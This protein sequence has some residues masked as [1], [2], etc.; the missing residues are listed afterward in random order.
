VPS[1]H[2]VDELT[3]NR[4]LLDITHYIRREPQHRFPI[5]GGS[6]GNVFRGTYSWRDANDDTPH[7][8]NVV[9]K[10]LMGTS[11]EKQKVEQ[12][13]N[14]EIATWR[15]LKHP[16]VAELLGIAYLNPTLPPGLVSRFAHRHDFLAY[17]GRHPDRKRRMV[18][19]NYLTLWQIGLL[20]YIFEGSGDSLW[21]GIFACKRHCAR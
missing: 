13:L 20:N 18:S 4:S 1:R 6:G 2:T 15:D 11:S 8:I 3:A 5:G 19:I 16:N 9:I 17:I 10:M 21:L 7:S 12:R 14:R